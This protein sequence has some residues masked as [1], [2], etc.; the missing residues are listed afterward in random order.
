MIVCDYMY[1]FLKN[2]LA[3]YC[4]YI[5]NELILSF[6]NGSEIHDVYYIM[7]NVF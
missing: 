5:V 6:K 7:I 2:P 4:S 1:F 3:L